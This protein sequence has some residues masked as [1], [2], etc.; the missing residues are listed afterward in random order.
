MKQIELICRI[1]E[2]VSREELTAAAARALGVGVKNVGECRLVR[3][4]IDARKDVICR[5]RYDVCSKSETLPGYELPPYQYVADAEPVVVIGAGPAGLFAALRLLMRGLKPVILERGKDI[6]GR[7][8]DVAAMMKTGKVN[9]DSNYC[10][11]EGGAGTFSD[12]KL[13]TRS[14]KRGDIREVLHQL[15][16]FGASESILTDA[17]PHI[18]T[19][20]LPEIMENIRK[21]IVEH[22]G[23]YHFNTRVT[24]IVRRGDGSLDVAAMSTVSGPPSEQE[25]SSAV[26][27]SRRVILAAGHSSREI[28]SLFERRGWAMEAKGFALGVRAEHPQSLI[29][30]IQ[31]HG[32]Y[33]PGMPAAEYSFVT[34]IEGRGVF[35]FCM[36]PGGILLPSATADGETVL[37]GMSNSRRD[38]RWANAGVVVS[39]E[40]G[41][42][43]EY[44]RFGVLSLMRFQEDVERKLFGW[45]NG[46]ASRTSPH[47]LAAPGQ[48]MMDFCRRIVSAGLPESSYKPGVISAPLHELL[49]ESISLRLKYAF[50]YIGDKFMRGYY[51]NEALLLGTESRTSSPVRLVRDPETLQSV[52]VEGLYPCGEG[53]GYAGGIVSSA[54]DGINVAAAV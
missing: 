52:S 46:P 6:H 33:Q 5:C 47:P 38:S 18:G 3:R 28:Y 27:N 20:R 10:F 16:R 45:V 11:G 1:G 4:S 42:L 49:P 23:E 24:D 19:D 13:F 40:P 31:Y 17:H 22:G 53:A 35:S 37:N 8:L 39:V 50:P 51:T 21:C 30:K 36:C 43:P 14:T 7:R 48:R 34:Q 9:P 41:D 44:E 12:G 54:L 25:T 32:K 15:V 26:Y 2:D 29:N